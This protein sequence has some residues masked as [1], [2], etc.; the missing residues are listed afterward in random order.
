MQCLC[1][2]DVKCRLPL[3]ELAFAIQYLSLVRAVQFIEIRCDL[4]MWICVCMFVKREEEENK[5]FEFER[6][7]LLVVEKYVEFSI[8]RYFFDSSV[9]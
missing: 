2:C 3:I 4:I 5:R 1:Q 9:N 8:V 6:Q 7:L